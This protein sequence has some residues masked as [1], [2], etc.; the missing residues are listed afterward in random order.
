VLTAAW[1]NTYLKDN[2]VALR[3]GGLAIASQATG[4]VFYAS[5]GTAAARLA[6]D[7]G[8]F[9]KSGASAPSWETISSG[10]TMLTKTANYTITETGSD[11]QVLCDASGGAFSITL[12]AAS[13]LAGFVVKVKKT[14]SSANAV[15]ADGSGSETIDGA[16]TQ[17]ISAR[18]TSLSMVCDGTNWH[19]F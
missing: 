10:V 12:K 6:K 15:T 3:A 18:Y 5:S 17:A 4:D 1:L 8:K 9:L 7:A 19:I 14:D 13:G 16:T 2:M 11:I